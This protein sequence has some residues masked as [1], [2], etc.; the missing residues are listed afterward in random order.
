VGFQAC[1]RC[2]AGN[3]RGCPAAWRP[4][5]VT[6]CGYSLRAPTPPRSPAGSLRL[7]TGARTPA[8]LCRGTSTCHGCSRASLLTSSCCPTEPRCTTVRRATG[9]PREA[10]PG[11]TA[12]GGQQGSATATVQVEV[13]LQQ[14]AGGARSVKGEGS[15][16]RSRRRWRAQ[17]VPA[18]GDACGR[19]AA[20]HPVR[21][22]APH[23]AQ[24]WNP[25]V[26]ALGQDALP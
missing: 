1:A 9:L 19:H 13:P 23:R 6:A 3:E 7:W 16:R 18:S 22:P 12:R 15:G 4:Q 24:A 20:R 5:G 10:P 25:T 17:A 2:G 14:V 11:P 21:F 8:N 26:R